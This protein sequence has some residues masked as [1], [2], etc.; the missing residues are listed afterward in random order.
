MLKGIKAFLLSVLTVGSLVATGNMVKEET[1]VAEA[2]TDYSKTIR[3]YWNGG[4]T[5][6]GVSWGGNVRVSTSNSSKPYYFVSTSGSDTQ[7]KKYDATL[8]SLVVDITS[9]STISYIQPEFT[10][11]EVTWKLN[12][13]KFSKTFT[14]GYQYIITYGLHW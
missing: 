6:A 11:W 10:E 9:T 8:G 14:P 12:V 1:K 13:T 4:N 5:N 2:A 7:G 3:I